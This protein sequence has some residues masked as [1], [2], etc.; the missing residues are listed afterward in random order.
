MLLMLFQIQ[1]NVKTL[2]QDRDNIQL[3]YEQVSVHHN[4]LVL[5]LRKNV[6][7]M[8][9]FRL[10]ARRH[11][12]SFPELALLLVSTK[13]RDLWSGPMTFRFWMAL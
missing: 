6:I 1:E 2:T 3:L 7:G 4:V 10:C 8:R 9:E 11:P 5:L 12:F 13:N